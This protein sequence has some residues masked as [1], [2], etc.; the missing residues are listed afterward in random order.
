M[1]IEESSI[2]DDRKWMN[3]YEK[4]NYYLQNSMYAEELLNNIDLDL[5]LL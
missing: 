3:R 4:K 5:I 2:D 1:T